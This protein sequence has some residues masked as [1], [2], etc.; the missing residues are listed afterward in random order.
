MPKQWTFRQDEVSSLLQ[1]RSE[2]WARDR[3][4]VADLWVGNK[5][6][7]SAM[8]ALLPSA[9][10]N[11]RRCRRITHTFLSV[12]MPAFFVFHGFFY[13]RRVYLTRVAPKLPED[14]LMNMS[15]I[16]HFIHD[17][18]RASAFHE[19]LVAQVSAALRPT[20]VVV[21]GIAAQIERV[22]CNVLVPVECILIYSRARFA[23]LQ[24]TLES[25]LSFLRFG[26]DTAGA[27][28]DTLSVDYAMEL[29]QDAF[30]YAA[31]AA[32]DAVYWGVP[33]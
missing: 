6:V 12:V 11:S 10:Y 19:R 7:E 32:H 14:P 31:G 29:A 8:T 13:I 21:A 30:D 16:A 28:T 18:F 9:I 27:L 2:L 3:E 24:R 25:L 5:Y 1:L 20:T 22:V 23:T 33:Q 4:L 17:R 15:S 26:Q